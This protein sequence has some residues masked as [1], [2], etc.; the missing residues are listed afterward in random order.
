MCCL[1]S[2]DLTSQF[3]RWPVAAYP[4]VID[5]PGDAKFSVPLMWKVDEEL[6]GDR[7]ASMTTPDG[8]TVEL[9]GQSSDQPLHASIQADMF[10][11]DPVA[12]KLP[13]D[14][15]KL[16]EDTD[17]KEGTWEY[18]RRAYLGDD[19]VYVMSYWLYRVGEGQYEFLIA[20]CIGTKDQVEKTYGA[21]D[22]VKAGLSIGETRLNPA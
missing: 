17:Q 19:K 15:K 1:Q 9:F 5:L 10:E 4:E 14:R 8:I 2:E 6:Q 16:T 21:A 22:A 11:S 7:F 13:S 18:L 20:R 3:P 12:S